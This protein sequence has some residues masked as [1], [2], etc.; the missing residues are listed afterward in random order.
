[1]DDSNLAL[2]VLSDDKNEKEDE[3]AR[4]IKQYKKYSKN[5]YV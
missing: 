5:G 2:A 4:F 3:Q 1:M